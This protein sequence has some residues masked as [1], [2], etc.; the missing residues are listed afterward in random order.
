MGV[1]LGTPAYMAPEQATADPG[2]DHRV[3]IYAYGIT[4]YEMLTG[5]TPFHGRSPHAMLGAQLAAIP[6]PMTSRRPGIPPVLAHLVMKCLEKRPADR[7]QTASEL[8]ATIDMLTTPSG[9]TVPLRAVPSG[10]VETVV[11]GA[12]RR[13]PH[14]RRG[15]GGIGAGDAGAWRRRGDVAASRGAGGRAAGGGGGGGMG[16][17]TQ[18]VHGGGPARA[19]RCRAGTCTGDDVPR[20]AG[21]GAADPVGGRAH[22][23]C[24]PAPVNPAGP[25]HQRGCHAGPDAQPGTGGAL[26]SRGGRRGQR[27]AGAGGCRAGDGGLAPGGAQDRQRRS[28][29]L[30]RHDV[31]ERRGGRGGG[32]GTNAA[33][34]HRLL[35]WRPPRPSRPRHGRPQPPRHRRLLRPSDRAPLRPRLPPIPRRPSARSSPIRPGDRSAQHPRDPSGL[36]RPLAGAEQGV[37]GLLR[38]GERRSTWTSRCPTWR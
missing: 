30:G 1:T 35:P 19:S 15:A 26:P 24:D 9:G 27:G 4:G 16:R 29:A 32:S 23:P 25:S 7:P 17:R 8:I 34:A 38:R 36:S 12:R 20:S 13:G 37:G 28:P 14:G 21:H 33:P 10:A 18:R 3:D 2:L 6:E 22:S 5:Q 31:L 11:T